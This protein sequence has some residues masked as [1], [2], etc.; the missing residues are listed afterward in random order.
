MLVPL[1]LTACDGGGGNTTVS[2]IVQKGA[3]Q[4]GSTIT[5][6]QLTATASD[7][8]NRSQGTVTNNLGAYTLTTNWSGWAEETVSG[9]FYDEYND[10]ITTAPVTLNSI[11]QIATGNQSINVNLFSHFVAARI[12][13]RVQNNSDSL[14]TAKTSAEGELQSALSLPAINSNQL[15]LHNGDGASSNANAV[16]LLF[17]G[18]FMSIGGNTT[19]LNT[20]TDDF[21]VDGTFETA[22]LQPI[23]IAAG[24][25][26]IMNTLA[27]NLSNKGVINPP[28][29]NDLSGLPNWV[30]PENTVP[31]ALAVNS[32]SNEDS[33]KAITLNGTDADGDSLTYVNVTDPTHGSVSI[34]GNT[35]TYTPDANY[36]GSDSFTYKVNDGTADSTAAT[37]SITVTA[38]NDAPVANAVSSIAQED[39]PKAITLNGSDIDGDSLTYIKVSDPTHGSISITGNTAT[40]TPIANYN[41]NDSFTYKV[42]DGMV[43]SATVAV[44]INVGGINDTPIAENISATTNEDTDK[45][46]TL[47]GS[48]AD[49]DSLTYIKATDPAHGSISITGNTATY[50]P[51]ANYNGSDSFTYK[52]NDGTADSTA[53]SVSITIAA[54]NDAPTANA[55]TNVQVLEGK[56][57]TLDG[58]ASTDPD[59]G[60]TL[61]YSWSP[62]T[63]LSS[64]T[65]PQPTFTAPSVSENT[66]QTLTLTVT[67]DA[68]PTANDTDT[69][70]ITILNLPAQPQNIQAQT[71]N[72]QVTISWNAVSDATSYDICQATETITDPT[73]C[74]ILENGAIRADSTSPSVITT[75]SNGTQYYFV[76]IPKN[77]NGAGQ[78]STVATATPV[79]VE[80]PTPT[81]KLNDTGITQCG[82]YAYGAGSGNHSNSEDCGNTTDAEGDPIPAGQD[83]TS[84]RDADSATNDNSDG[85]KGFSYTKLDVNGVALADQ[86]ANTFSCIKDNVTGL[87]W[88]VKTDD[89]GLQDKGHRYNWYSQDITTN[90]GNSGYSGD[91]QLYTGTLQPGDYTLSVSYE[92]DGSVST[93]DDEVYI[94]HLL[95][96][97]V[98]TN[99]QLHLFDF[100][101]GALPV[102]WQQT[103]GSDASWVSSDTAKIGSKGLKNTDIDDSQTASVDWIVTF[104]EAVNISFYY[105]AS[106]EGGFDFLKFKVNATEV[107]RHSGSV[108]AI[109]CGLPLCNTEAY[110]A[111]VNASSNGNGICGAT[112]WR[113]PTREELRSLISRDRFSPAI[114]TDYFPNT[115]SSLYWSSSPYAPNGAGAWGV[116]FD[117]GSDGASSKFNSNYVRLVRSGQ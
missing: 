80:Q 75:L 66:E 109:G 17:S 28:D 24:E 44:S 76:V 108:P 71:G 4:T 2:G 111:S 83:A 32:S 103:P 51:D 62:A 77:T 25:A 79:G 64:A 47:T 82:D 78:A 65:A 69:V 27:S 113:L 55:G 23:A 3:F 85:H 102:E 88:E 37:V 96:E 99:N 45:A 90:G 73:N 58:T 40:Y 92:K 7:G 8:T 112:D 87:I 38:V 54:I 26:G 5:L 93:T 115:I 97:S 72:Q 57:I 11:Q 21:K 91:W 94:D 53:A 12:K 100:E 86:S 48:D 106:S 43:D 60:D 89:N 110:V 22:N 61:S 59:T 13:Y 114:D 56:T 105:H 68:N 74:A 19:L 67:D 1:A 30:I 9:Q 42:N 95:V 107:F 52:V 104:T 36:N 14:A 63:N 50:T 33:N 98:D 116:G 10:Q 117:N 41:G 18:S 70:T 16:L 35:A 20:L 34:T 46:I 81:G 84:G 39:T 101:D 29:A 49:G 6:Q 31:V 15:D